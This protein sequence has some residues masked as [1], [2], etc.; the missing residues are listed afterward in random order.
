MLGVEADTRT[1]RKKPAAVAHACNC[2]VQEAEASSGQSGLQR[3]SVGT[4]TRQQN[5]PKTKR[6]WDAAQW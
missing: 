3:D 5:T 4:K 6:D 2:S 1:Q